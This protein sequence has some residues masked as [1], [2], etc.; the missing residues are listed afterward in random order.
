M[1]DRSWLECLMPGVP[2]CRGTFFRPSAQVVAVLHVL[3]KALKSVSL[4]EE[5]RV[6]RPAREASD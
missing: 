1:T 3:P 4:G 5:R 2:G 6:W